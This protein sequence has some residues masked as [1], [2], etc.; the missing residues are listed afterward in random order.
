MYYN[1]WGCWFHKADEG[2]EKDRMAATIRDGLKLN[3][4]AAILKEFIGLGSVIQ[5]RSGAVVVAFGSRMEG[6]FSPAVAETLALHSGLLCVLRY[7]I[8]VSDRR[9]SCMYK[10]SLTFLLM[11]AFSM[12]LR[13]WRGMWVS[14]CCFTPREGNNVAHFL[15][16]LA[17]SSPLFKIR[18]VF[19]M[20]LQSLFLAIWFNGMLSYDFL[21]K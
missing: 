18:L 2:Q 19:W 12:L 16:L 8:R 9:V 13:V 11:V 17:A 20:L 5:D 7:N 10:L 21:K 4:D 14:S 6:W 3:T 15:A 1:G